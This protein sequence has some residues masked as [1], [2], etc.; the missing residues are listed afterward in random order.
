MGRGGRSQ[1]SAQVG[2]LGAGPGWGEDRAR[3][4][5]VYVVDVRN[6]LYVLRYAG[7]VAGEVNGLTFLEGNSNLGD[8]G[9]LDKSAGP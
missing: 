1:D 2:V 6:G 3:R 4:I 5:L 8:A 7:P 9:R